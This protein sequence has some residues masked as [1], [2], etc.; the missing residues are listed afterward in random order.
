MEN[1]LT[2]GRLRRSEIAGLSSEKIETSRP[3]YVRGVVAPPDRRLQRRATSPHNQA[4]IARIAEK[5]RDH[6]GMEN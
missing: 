2:A 3:R 1:V 6:G 4:H 5:E